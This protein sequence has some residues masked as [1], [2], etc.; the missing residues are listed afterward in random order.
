MG[1][2]PLPPT[3]PRRRVGGEETGG[4]RPSPTGRSE[5]GA[6]GGLKGPGVAVVT[7]VFSL[8]DGEFFLYIYIFPYIF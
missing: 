6:S 1:N 5:A 3:S 2:I 7:K 8:L 4:P